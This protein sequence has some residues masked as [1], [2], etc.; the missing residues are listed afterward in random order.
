MDYV[1]C[2]IVADNVVM[3]SSIIFT[4]RFLKKM[5]GIKGYYLIWNRVDCRENSEVYDMW[6]MILEDLEVP[7]LK[8]Q[9]SNILRFHKEKSEARKCVSFNGSIR[10]RR[11]R[12]SE[13]RRRQFSDLSAS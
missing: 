5:L 4:E 12:D 9:M 3:K 1:F 8:T 2:L 6:A 11:K 7:V 10:Y 13:G